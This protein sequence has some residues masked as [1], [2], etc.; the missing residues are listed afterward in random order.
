MVRHA[1]PRETRDSDPMA[2]S[3]V[4]Q[5]LDLARATSAHRSALDQSWLARTDPSH[6][7]G[8]PDYGGAPRI[9]GELRMLGIAVS[10]RTVSRY[11][12]RQRPSPGAL[13]RWFQ[14]L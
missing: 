6:G 1:R 7:C 12:P 13:E 4:P 14:F 5:V 9:H 3:R 2:P 10:E 11:L 8:E